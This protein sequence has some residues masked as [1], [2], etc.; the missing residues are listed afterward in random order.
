MSAAVR[1]RPAVRQIFAGIRQT[2][3]AAFRR[4]WADVE[5]FGSCKSLYRLTFGAIFG[6]FPDFSR[7]RDTAGR[8]EKSVRTKK[9]GIFKRFLLKKQHT[10]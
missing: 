2:F 6:N 3:R 4:F 9:T 7:R 1:D 10:N 8:S 5:I